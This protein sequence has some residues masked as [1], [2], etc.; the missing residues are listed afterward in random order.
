MNA[1]ASIVDALINLY[2]TKQGKRSQI[3]RHT[4]THG[5][6]SQYFDGHRRLSQSEESK[7]T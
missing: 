1:D 7:C 2:I 4:Q 6:Y 5:N 3:E